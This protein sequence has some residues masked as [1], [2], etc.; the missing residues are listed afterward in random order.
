MSKETVGEYLKRERKLREITLQ[1]VAEGTK[2]SIRS[3][4]SIEA[5]RFADL[6]AEVFLR[7]FVRSYAAYIGI[8]PEDAIL[9]LEDDMAKPESDSQNIKISSPDID[10]DHGGDDRLV[11]IRIIVAIAA[12]V[13]LLIGAYFLFFHRSPEKRLRPTE[14]SRA[15]GSNISKEAPVPDVGLQILLEQ[16]ED[17]TKPDIHDSSDN[18]PAQ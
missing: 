12:A 11:R 9:R 3:L 13:L 17:R 8:D 16:E 15:V 10:M 1:E 18:G 6:P 14:G 7:G 2:I 5:N 4:E